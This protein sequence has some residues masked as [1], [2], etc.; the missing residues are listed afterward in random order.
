[1]SKLE[2]NIPH[3]LG[4]EEALTRVQTLLKRIQMQ[5]GSQVQDVQ[6]E[7]HGNQGSFSFKVMNMPVSGTLTVNNADVALDSKLPLAA[8]M[9]SGKIKSVIMEEAKKV[10]S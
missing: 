2:M 7:W 10:L 1:M 8:A 3:E 9:F 5:F 6:E 4:Q